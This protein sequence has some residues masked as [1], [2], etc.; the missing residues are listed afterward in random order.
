MYVNNTH[1]QA[2]AHSAHFIN[3]EIQVRESYSLAETFQRSPILIPNTRKYTHTHTLWGILYSVWRG[4]HV[5]EVLQSDL[6]V[7]WGV[8]VV[9]G[10][11]PEVLE[12]YDR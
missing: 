9:L 3:K 5:G 10:V 8:L 6:Q 4:M 12:V 7:S 11:V 1:A 2:H